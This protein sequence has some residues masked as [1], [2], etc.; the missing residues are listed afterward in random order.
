[1]KIKKLIGSML[2]AFS[3]VFMTGC[4]SD[5]KGAVEACMEAVKVM[6]LSSIATSDVEESINQGDTILNSLKEYFNETSSKIEYKIQDTKVN[7]D[8][9]TVTVEMTYTDAT[10]IYS[11]VMED[12][13]KNPLQ[14]SFS[15]E[16]ATGKI[17]LFVSSFNGL[18]DSVKTNTAKCTVK[19]E[20]MKESGGWLVD[21][22]SDEFVDVITANAY[23]FFNNLE[24]NDKK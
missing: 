17:E 19:F 23:T 7:G 15:G 22:V 8:K 9:A 13:F 10:P 18:K 1:M 6:D 4:A 12:A 16:D 24:G 2:C 14:Y 5:P 20:C 11:A 3:L 21:D